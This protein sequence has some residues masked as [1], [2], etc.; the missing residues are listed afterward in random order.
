MQT[1]N[2]INKKIGKG[3]PCFIIAEIGINHN[4]DMNLACKMIDVAATTGVDAVKFQ[5]YYTDD[6]ITDQSLKY[7]YVSQGKTIVE[8]QYEMF[9]R[10]ELKPENLKILKD[11]CKK[12]GIIFFST[13]S[14]EMGLKDIIKIGVPLLKNGSD[15]L[16]HLPLI[17]QMAKTGLPTL[18]STGMATLADIDNAVGTYIKAGGNGLIL[19]HCTSSYPT[20]SDEV[21]LLKINSLS[22]AFGCHVGF[23][24]HTWGVTAAIGAVTLGACVVEK[25]YTLDKN[26]PGPDHR[27]SADPD[28]LKSLVNGI[29]AIEKNLGHSKICPT[30]SEEMGRKEYRYSCIAAKDLSIGHVLSKEDVAFQRPGTGLAPK[31]IDLMLSKTLKRSIKKGDFFQFSDFE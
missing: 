23:S 12:T 13:P 6:F 28:E 24:D 19:L 7:E 26:L 4:G 9:K 30:P 17:K 5:N 1:I 15:C 31:H 2:I 18:I 16:T 29:R 21:H 20:P 11:H 10:Y 8:S 22:T 14:S 27:F 25:H 3:W